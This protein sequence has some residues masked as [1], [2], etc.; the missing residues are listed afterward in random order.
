ML[1]CEESSHNLIKCQ[2]VLVSYRE[3]KGCETDTLSIRPPLPSNYYIDI[4]TLNAGFVMSVV[5][6]NFQ[7]F[8]SKVAFF[9]KPVCFLWYD[10]RNFQF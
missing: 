9:H 7:Y 2:P 6:V 1:D 5:V 10:V 3:S 4:D 8:F